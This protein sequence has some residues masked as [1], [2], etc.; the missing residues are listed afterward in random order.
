MQLQTKVKTGEGIAWIRI[1]ENILTVVDSVK[2]DS[3]TDG[4]WLK[5]ITR[6]T[7]YLLGTSGE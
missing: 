6:C 1:L 3:V 7:I 5:T 4:E 2:I